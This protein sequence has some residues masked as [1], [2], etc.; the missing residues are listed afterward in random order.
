MTTEID[1]NE[2]LSVASPNPPA[3]FSSFNTVRI[4]GVNVSDQ[5]S[6]G[7]DAG[8]ALY[9][10]TANVEWRTDGLA[11][12]AYVRHIYSGDQSVQSQAVF[13]PWSQITQVF[14]INLAY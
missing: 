12:T 4:I 14:G 11:F 6:T 2:T 13:Y 1:V 10:P 3:W 5:V 9:V 7:A 8:A